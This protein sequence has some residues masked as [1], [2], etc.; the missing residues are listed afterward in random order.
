LLIV[1]VKYVNGL[2]IKQ[3]DALI[4]EI[5]EDG[6]GLSNEEKNRLVDRKE[7]KNFLANP[8]QI[9]KYLNL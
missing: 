3:W 9:A 8:K 5:E 6:S 7:L 4:A 1:I 2:E